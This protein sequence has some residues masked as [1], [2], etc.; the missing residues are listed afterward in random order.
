MRKI[1]DFGAN[2]GPA[3]AKDPAN[4]TAR[5]KLPTRSR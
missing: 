3:A 4:K 5:Q 1:P 2:H